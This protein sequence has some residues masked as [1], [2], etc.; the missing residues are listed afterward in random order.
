M[1]GS[2]SLKLSAPANR[3]ESLLRPWPFGDFR[4]RDWS[5]ILDDFRGRPRRRA[6]GQAARFLRA[7]VFRHL[8][9]RRDIRANGKDVHGLAR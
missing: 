9:R 5:R 2:C 3:S 1:R 4:A 6:R 7:S 8:I